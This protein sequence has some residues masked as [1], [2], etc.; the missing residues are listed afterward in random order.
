MGGKIGNATVK[1]I[2]EKSVTLNGDNQEVLKL[3]IVQQSPF[4]GGWVND[5]GRNDK[6]PPPKKKNN[7]PSD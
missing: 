6:P 1:S 4:L 5:K 2:D 7:G 3:N